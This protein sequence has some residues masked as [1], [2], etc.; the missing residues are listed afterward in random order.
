L[1]K[2]SCNVTECKPLVI[3]VKHPRYR[4]FGDIVN[5]AARMQARS[6]P[7]QGLTLVHSQLILICF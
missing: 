3:G 5:T 6:D 2:F 4:L 1:I 7:G